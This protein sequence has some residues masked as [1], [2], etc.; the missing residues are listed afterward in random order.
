MIPLLLTAL[1]D[2]GSGHYIHAYLEL[3]PD[4][5]ELVKTRRAAFLAAESVSSDVVRLVFDNEHTNLIIWLNDEAPLTR[6]EGKQMGRDGWIQLSEPLKVEPDDDAVEELDTSWAEMHV[7]DTEVYFSCF[8]DQA[9]ENY[10]TVRLSYE[11]L[12]Q[13]LKEAKP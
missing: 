6:H 8:S 2:T 3:T 9:C 1:E 13:L 11:L 5:L 12:E 10:N 7:S 4:L